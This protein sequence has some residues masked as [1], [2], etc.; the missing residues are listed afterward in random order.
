M[1]EVRM[2]VKAREWDIEPVVTIALKHSE[3]QVK[4]RTYSTHPY[5]LTLTLS[6]THT[7]ALSLTHTL[8]LSHPHTLT[9]PRSLTRSL[10]LSLSRSLTLGSQ[11]KS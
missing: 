5:R 8:A 7:L 10:A 1:R 4:L 9:H 3:C 2:G 6:L 11:N